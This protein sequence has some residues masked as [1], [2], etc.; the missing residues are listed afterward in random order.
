MTSHSEISEQGAEEK[1]VTFRVADQL[2]GLPATR[3][4]DVL[5]P[6][7]LMPV[8]LA[9]PYVAGAMNLRGHIVTAI[10]L[11]CKLGITPSELNAKSMCLVIDHQGELVSLLVDAIGDVM[12]VPKKEI[13]SNPASLTEAWKK[14][15][16]GIVR[17]TKE[18][19]V[20]LQADALLQT[21]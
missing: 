1:L 14:V 18:L 5:R 20:V 4:R 17:L 15:S 9:K 11:R 8:P 13:I 12:D 19:L 3:V 2:F 10:N 16:F 6:S 7:A 21:A